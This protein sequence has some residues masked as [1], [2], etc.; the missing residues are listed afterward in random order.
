VPLVHHVVIGGDD[1]R[2][3]RIRVIVEIDK[4]PCREVLLVFRKWLR[5]SVEAAVWEDTFERHD[6]RVLTTS[7]GRGRGG[8]LLGRRGN[9][10]FTRREQSELEANDR[11]VPL[12]LDPDH[13]GASNQ[14]RR[15]RIPNCDLELV[16]EGHLFLENE[17][18][19]AAAHVERPAFI[20]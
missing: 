2:Q 9:G 8:S 16:A 10:T 11:T 12:L 14:G 1:D 15:L 7:A 6:G 19:P 3:S 13:A 20:G 5:G 17:P 18:D 4:L